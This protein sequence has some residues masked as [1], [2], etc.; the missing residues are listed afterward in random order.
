MKLTREQHLE[1]CKQCTQRKFDLDKG[2]ICSLTGEIADFEDTCEAYKEDQQ[3]VANQKLWQTSPPGLF[4]KSVE[5][6]STEELEK[7][8]QQQSYPKAVMAGVIGTGIG[9][10]CSVVLRIGIEL[11]VF[12]D[13]MV[14]MLGVISGVAIRLFGK[15]IDKKFAQLGVYLTIWGWYLSNVFIL[16]HLFKPKP[17]L[18]SFIIFFEVFFKFLLI[19]PLFILMHLSLCLIGCILAYKIARKVV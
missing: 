13:F 2:I 10:F 1:L 3:V 7:L 12:L 5:K 4:A 8:R 17:V 6:V 18:L 15:G 16:A 9:V 11:L 19:A 14:I